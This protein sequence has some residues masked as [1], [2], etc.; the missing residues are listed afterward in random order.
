MESTV[1]GRLVKVSHQILVIRQYPRSV[2][3]GELG[4]A[5]RGG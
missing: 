5:S 4:G 3:L 1:V 2:R